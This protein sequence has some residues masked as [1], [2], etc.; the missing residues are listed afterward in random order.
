MKWILSVF[1]SLALAVAILSI[2]SPII[3]SQAS[4]NRMNGKGMGC[5]EGMNCMSGRA[6]VAARRGQK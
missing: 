5:S 2:P 6:K 3:S 4:A 1:A